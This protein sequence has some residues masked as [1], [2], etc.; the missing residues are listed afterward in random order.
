MKRDVGDERFVLFLWILSSRR[1]HGPDCGRG[2]AE[3]EALERGWGCKERARCLRRRRSG[4]GGGEKEG[5]EGRGRKVEDEA[6]KEVQEDD[7][8]CTMIYTLR[9]EYG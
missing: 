9:L 5:R 4:G 1:R 7:A 6:M 2:E 8:V 3:A